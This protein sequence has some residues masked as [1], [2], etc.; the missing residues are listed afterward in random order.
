MILTLLL[1]C[2]PESPSEKITSN[3]PESFFRAVCAEPESALQRRTLEAIFDRVGSTDC[4][5]VHQ[6]LSKTKSL[7]L[8]NHPS[9]FTEI[10]PLKEFTQIEELYLSDSRVVDLTPLDG[11][12]KLRLLH[13]EHCDI[14][15]IAVLKNMPLLEDLL[16]DYTRVSDLSPL[17]KSTKIKRLGLRS[18][19]VDSLEVL[20]NFP[21]LSYLEASKT[22]ISEMESLALLNN[23]EVVSLR[24]TAISD[25]TSL[26][27]HT[28]LFF[29]DLHQTDVVD[30]S[31]LQQLSQLKVLDISKTKV[32]DLSPLTSQA[33][34]LLELNV[35]GTQIDDSVCA[36]YTGSIRGCTPLE[37]DVF[38]TL[39]TSPQ[40]FPFS[41]QVSLSSL[42]KEI[43]ET[44]CKKMTEKMSKIKDFSSQRHYPDPRIFSHFP[45]INN[46]QIPVEKIYLKF[47]PIK[48]GTQALKKLCIEKRTA[49]RKASEV[50]KSEFIENCES[51]PK[52]SKAVYLMLNSLSKKNSCA[53][54]WEW[55]KDKEKLSFQDSEITDMS[56]LMFFP[57][58]K[59][60]SLDYNSIRDLSPLSQLT[61]LQVLWIDDNE[62][63]DLT[64][65]QNLDLLWLSAGD[66]QIQDISALASQVN[67][68]RLWLG[69]NQIS[70]IIPLEKM[71]DL[72]K[73][74]LAIN[75]IEDIS[76]LASLIQLTSLYLGRNKVKD[77]RPLNN[78]NRL[79][80]LNSG[81]DHDET[82]LEVQRWFLN[83]NPI[84]EA[85]CP[86]SN[87]PTT[88]TLFCS[89]YK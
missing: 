20:S 6:H 68:Q 66:N 76:P 74:H 1:S 81:L 53:E 40:N 3:K 14:E 44:D 19:K 87:V 55:M 82:P 34:T 38:L 61:N 21:E 77:I 31:P 75:Q 84:E 24:N 85:F 88:V 51:D 80:V 60:L 65:L 72:R 37:E 9:N 50:F 13:V 23:L 29:I 30:L 16:L 49:M 46:L 54:I 89:Q 41:S 17:K 86:K 67:L 42:Q 56:P 79:H 64:P 36:Q 25:I 12:E 26:A 83:G 27:N 43:K 45:Q 57:N 58:I 8:A 63:Q 15:D 32:S 39:C 70:D 7:N 59:E 62:I 35:E 33:S 2:S 71:T 78:L 22:S 4:D 5:F 69:G 48:K 28:K 73:L 11:Y 52:E 47:C 18:T 10:D